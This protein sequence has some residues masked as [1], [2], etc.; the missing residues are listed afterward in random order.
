MRRRFLFGWILAYAP[1]LAL[2]HAVP[3]HQNITRAAVDYLAK[4]DEKATCSSN[5]NQLLQVGTAAEDDGTRPVFHFTPALTASNSSCS[6]VAWGFGTGAC[7]YG[8]AGLTF[9]STN[10]HR[11]PDALAHVVD[12]KGNP[13]EE[14]LRDLGFVLHLLEDLS[15]PAHTRDDDHLNIGGYGDIDP[16]EAVTRNPTSPPISEGLLAVGSPQ[17]F[18][19]QL[20][21]FTSSNFYSKDTVF[22]NGGPIATAQDANYFYD[23]KGRRIAYKSASYRTEELFGLTPDPTDA[24]INDVI[25]TEH[26]PN[27][28]RSRS[29]TPRRSSS[30]TWT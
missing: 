3:T 21:Q 8:K 10:T 11:W 30:I 5:L 4:L 2:P 6:S 19:Q 20:R 9:A 18:F 26:S 16:V 25:A 15:S 7:Q 28:A 23:A 17:L 12:A 24:T 29:N 14:G 13:S 22:S 1:T 27:L